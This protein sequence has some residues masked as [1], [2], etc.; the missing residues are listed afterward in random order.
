M[1][2]VEDA[3]HYNM[4]KA[5]F[6]NTDA[7]PCIGITP[8]A[9]TRTYYYYDFD[10]IWAQDAK[11]YDSP[12]SMAA[13]F[14]TAYMAE[15]R[16]SSSEASL[17]YSPIK[18]YLDADITSGLLFSAGTITAPE[19]PSAVTYAS[20]A[21]TEIVKSTT[22]SNSFNIFVQKDAGI[23]RPTSADGDTSAYSTTSTAGVIGLA[24]EFDQHYNY[25]KFTLSDLAAG[26]VEAN[27][28]DSL[29]ANTKYGSS[30]L[31][32]I[33]RYFT[34]PEWDV[35]PNGTDGDHVLKLSSGYKV[36]MS[37][38]DV[39]V[40]VSDCEDL[41]GLN[42]ARGIILTKGDVYFENGVNKFEGLIVAGD[43]IFVGGN[44]RSISANAEICKAIIAELQT[45]KDIDAEKVLRAFNG[46][47]T[48]YDELSIDELKTLCGNR[49]ITVESGDTKETLISKL[50]SY[51]KNGDESVKKIDTIDYSDVV[52]YSNWMKNAE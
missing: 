14:A 33:N 46:Y 50:L 22:G 7:V 47:S 41:D 5:F 49:G 39:C 8:A 15:L 43:K 19:D 26:S 27:F 3:S 31:S 11:G 40:K 4:F 12:E 30:A 51:D 36:W 9:S 45:D 18:D 17:D 2:L 20:G 32:P 29:V 28:V 10:R 21:L 24:S 52:K 25:L 1:L 42:T 35:S 48:E 44:M 37:N 38:K 6:S 16:K 23:T 34:I 13:A